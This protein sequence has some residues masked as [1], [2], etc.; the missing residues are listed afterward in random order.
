VIKIAGAEAEVTGTEPDSAP[1]YPLNA[2]GV[3]G[4]GRLRQRTRGVPTTFDAAH[5]IGPSVQYTL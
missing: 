3:A 1:Q 4:G 2:H 5:R